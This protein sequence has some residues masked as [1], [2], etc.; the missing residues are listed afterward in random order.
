MLT[1]YEIKAFLNILPSIFLGE[2]NLT[3]ILSIFEKD[4][5][6]LA[7]HFP[8][9]FPFSSNELLII[10]L[11]LFDTSVLIS[12]LILILFSDFIFCSYS[13]VFFSF[14]SSLSWLTLTCLFLTNSPTTEINSSI[15]QLFKSRPF[16]PF[17]DWRKV[18]NSSASYP[19]SK[20]F[21]LR[22]LCFDWRS[23]SIFNY[24]IL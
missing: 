19:I 5:I 21:S 7:W 9:K 22:K 13:S 10:E 12:W 17:F 11:I 15:F 14:F 23:S 16:S 6:S 24:L 8:I 4:V 2:D 20:T 1:L 3:F 18:I